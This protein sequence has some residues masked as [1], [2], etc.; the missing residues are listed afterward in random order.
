MRDDELDR[1]GAELN[2]LGPTEA[3]P[4]G[5]L[6]RITAWLEQL[7]RAS[8]SDL[9]LVA[10]LPPSIIKD[11]SVAHDPLDGVIDGADVEDAVLPALSPHARTMYRATG[12]ADGSF[13]VARLGR[14]R[15][16]LHRERGTAFAPAARPGRGCRSDEHRKDNHDRGAD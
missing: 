11:G 4:A 12:I 16:N 15:I 13:K 14:F 7:V 5:E 2:A 10:G 9:L 8:G 6:A 3:P 1:L